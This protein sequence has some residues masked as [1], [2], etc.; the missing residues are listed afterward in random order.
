MNDNL[1]N[2]LEY[3]VSELSTSIK[4]IIEDNFDYIKLKAEVGR[5]S[6]PKSG[7]IYLDL[8]DDTSVISGI[9]WKGNVNKLKILPEEGLEVVCTGKVTTYAGQSKYQIII[10]N[11]EPYGIGALMALLEKRKEKLLKE[12]LFDDNFKKEIPF[13]PKRIGVI[14]SPTGAVIRDILHRIEDRF[15][16]NVTLWPVKVQGDSSPEEIIDAIEGFQL[17]DQSNLEKPDVIIIARGGG[18]VEDL[19]GFNDENLV[20]K[21]FDSKIPIISAI[22]HETDNTLI[23]L[24]ADLRA[25][26]PTAAAEM[27]VP[28][29]KNLLI[30][31]K[32]SYERI[33]NYINN[34]I[35]YEKRSLLL[36]DKTI[37]K[38]EVLLKN[39][40][41]RYKKASSILNIS[42]VSMIKHYQDVF[43]RKTISFK[44]NMLTKNLNLTKDNFLDISK[45]LINSTVSIIDKKVNSLQLQSGLLDVLS[46]ES[47][48]KRGFAIVKNKKSKIIKSSK[49]LNKDE[50][51]IINFYRNDKLN[52]I[53]KRDE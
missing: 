9:I 21:V 34:R 7:H 52:V 40:N 30:S 20:R 6:Q 38:I 41:L 18:S 27:A 19:W 44:A 45:S 50:E 11:I 3:T 43:L 26:T 39:Y 42:L 35:E 22:G 46:H 5:V 13:L 47:V 1:I 24:V 36:L 53:L 16:V 10:E 23:D 32:D 37:P 28:V 29:R 2:N 14:T 51:L 31:V 33:R 17:L 8:K 25:P 12:N 49:K 4:R 15:P 48:L